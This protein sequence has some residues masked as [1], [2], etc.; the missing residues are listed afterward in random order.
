MKQRGDRGTALFPG[1]TAGLFAVVLGL[2][3]CETEEI[4]ELTRI[5]RTTMVHRAE[6]MELI[7]HR[8]ERERELRIVEQRLLIHCPPSDE[9]A[10]L[11]RLTQTVG[12]ADLK[13][14]IE[15][16]PGRLQ[17]Q[18]TGAA[19]D[20]VEVLRALGEG[21]PFLSLEE[22]SLHHEEWSM[23]LAP[24]AACPTLGQVA[25]EVTR[26]PLPA[27]GVFWRGTSNALRAKIIA[28]ERDL[29]QWESTVLAGG[30][31]KLNS[32]WALLERLRDQQRDG[33]GHLMG[34][35]PL[36]EGLLA[37]LVGPAMTLSRKEDGVWFLERD[38][39]G[40]DAAWVV[41]LG[42]AGYRLRTD[43]SGRLMLMHESKLKQTP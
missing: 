40:M 20:I 4:R 22:L 29:Q 8:E 43:R 15:G 27:R 32:R 37:T 26:Y 1:R 21:A 34:Q 11:S 14:R 30:V 13:I 28:T 12:R 25:A 10:L 38:V 24:G 39:A 7:A 3:A 17:L 31:A 6:M 33:P 35:L 5:H 9:H 16:S 36:L 23:E 42:R 41:R 19:G 18:G 2:C